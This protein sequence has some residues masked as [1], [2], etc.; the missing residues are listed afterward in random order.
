MPAVK[1]D[2]DYHR[3]VGEELAD[4]RALL[5]SLPSEQWDGETL[6]A[7]W[8]VRD[9][10]GHMCV[11][12]TMNLVTFPF[13][14]AR[15]GFNVPKGSHELSVRYGSSHTPEQLLEVF[16]RE[17]T[18]DRP[19]GLGRIIPDR[20]RFTDHL[21][22]QQDIRRPIGLARDVPPERIVAAMDAL[23]AIGGFLQSRRTCAGLRFVATDVG[24]AVGEG[25]EVSG[26]GEALV[27][28][29]SGRPV[30]LAEL[31]GPGL[32]TLRGR[33]AG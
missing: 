26:P 15:Y 11:G 10:V 29:M 19:G 2:H 9:V 7:G 1:A 17:T 32:E 31:S 30:A 20:E 6:C 25:A 5:H 14:L 4:L 28:A 8:R 27:L 21:I 33:I 22:H 12:Y 23:P 3:L 13:K 18:K 16:D 24:H